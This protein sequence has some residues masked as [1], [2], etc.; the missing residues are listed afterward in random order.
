M[1]RKGLLLSLV[2]ILTSGLASSVISEERCNEDVCIA[3]RFPFNRDIFTIPPECVPYLIILPD[4][5]N[6]TTFVCVQLYRLN[7]NGQA[8][9][10]YKKLYKM[11]KTDNVRDVKEKFPKIASKKSG[12][13]IL[14]VSM[15]GTEPTGSTA[16][17]DEWAEESKTVNFCIKWKKETG[18]TGNV[19][20]S[21]D[22]L[23]SDSSGTD[24]A[25]PH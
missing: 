1:K 10:V 14:A 13:F 6:D 20:T 15:A 8:E 12:S 7:Q 21:S 24:G 3:A 19:P 18:G 17:L 16:D 9:R 23:G 11:P 4:V 2:V 22:S 5:P 25:P